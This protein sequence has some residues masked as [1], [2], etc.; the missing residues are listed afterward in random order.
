[1]RLHQAGIAVVSAVALASIGAAHY[2][3]PDGSRSQSP[4][5]TIHEWGTFTSVAGPDGRAIDWLPL[6][7]PSD[8]PCFVKHVN[9]NVIAKV[10]P[11]G[12]GAQVSYEQALTR[13]YGKV[14]METP[15]IYFYS[16]TAL[17]ASVS[18][19][20]NRGVITEFYP[21]PSQPTLALYA[22]TLSD[23][24]WSHSM[25]WNVKVLPG[26]SPIYPNGGGESHYYAARNTDASPIK[27]GVESEK[28]IF[29]RGVASFDVPIQTKVLAGGDVEIWN[30]L[31][32]GSMPTVILFESRAGRVGFR[33]GGE[34][35]R[36]ITLAPPSLTSDTAAI[37]KELREQLERAGL[38]PKEARAMVDT[39]RDSWFE[40][41]SRVFYILPQR[42][43]D[44]ILPLHVTPAPTTVSRVF[45]GRM[46]LI[47]D[48][49]MAAV[50]TALEQNDTA[51]LD[52]YGR[53]LSP[54][55]QRIIANGSDATIN[56]RI[57]TA[58]NTALKKYLTQLR[59]CE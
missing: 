51:M 19:R 49:S 43:V 45:V 21:T 28:F 15:V 38:F 13:M 27:S 10:L 7:G 48:A 40:E 55:T 32:E 20:F 17:D 30:I 8:L 14:R 12:A 24:S 6:S 31:P 16:P 59:A 54:I 29:Y 46:E 4:G 35:S 44:A 9:A 39:W 56:A 11:T 41:G 57:S 50:K 25:D 37:R 42:E 22:A 36:S 53:F 18:V 5:L 3:L 52:R 2:G 34:V 47:D 26:T 33:V 1:M 58:A 23:P